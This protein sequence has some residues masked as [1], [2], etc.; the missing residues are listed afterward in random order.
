MAATT[1]IRL[2]PELRAKLSA[3]ARETG[4]SVH[5]LIVE[6]VERY[7]AYEVELRD[8]VKAARDA[9][10]DIERIGEVYRAEDVH[11]W[12][13]RLAQGESA[14]RTKDGPNDRPKPWRR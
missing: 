6:G 9:D 5:S 7:A 8:L 10:A 4:R 11:A 1:T 2:P 14:D 12:I 3:L 13:Q